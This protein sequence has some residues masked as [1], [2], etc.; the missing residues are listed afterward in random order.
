MKHPSSIL[1]ALTLTLG[2]GCTP[3][4]QVVAPD[5]PIVINLNIKIEQ[6]VRVRLEDDVRALIES[7]E[8]EVTTRDVNSR[9]ARLKAAKKA[10]LLGE[11]YDGLVGAVET[12]LPEPLASLKAEENTARV[13][14]YR[15]LAREQNVPVDAV[16]QLAGERRLAS[17]DHGEFRL[18]L[19]G[20]WRRMD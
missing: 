2:I 14:V 17:A 7:E 12:R 10:G 19:D 20:Q 13:V 8:D 9:S 6:E 18:G 11:R 4:V 3:A 16:R 15:A 1:A 5:E